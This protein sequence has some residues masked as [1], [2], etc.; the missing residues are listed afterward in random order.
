LE[1][2]KDFYLITKDKGIIGRIV[3]ETD[4][5][6]TV[7]WGESVTERH[8]KKELSQTCVLFHGTRSEAREFVLLGKHRKS[9]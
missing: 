1:N 3:D 8:D 9:C 5:T 4:D 7:V 2:N 6:M